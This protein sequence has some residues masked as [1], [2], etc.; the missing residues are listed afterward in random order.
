MHRGFRM[1]VAG[2][3]GIATMATASQPARAAEYYKVS[4][5]R[6]SQNIYREETSRAIIATRYCYEYA[7]SEDAI[8]VW[9]GPYS[10]SNKLI[11]TNMSNECEVEGVYRR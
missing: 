6:I 10:F 1:G 11:F 3:I 2:L 9:D 7:Y 8:L 5:T 4:V